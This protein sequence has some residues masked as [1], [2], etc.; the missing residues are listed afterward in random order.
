MNPSEQE[1]TEQKILEL[2]YSGPGPNDALVLEM[3]KNSFYNKRF[4]G[5]L[6]TI[7]LTTQSEQLATEV[8]E[9]LA[10]HTSDQQILKIK[11]SVK[12]GN[13]KVHEHYLQTDFD[14]SLMVDILYTDFR[15]SGNSYFEFLKVDDGTHPDRKTI[16]QTFLN[17]FFN[18]NGY[19]TIPMLMPDELAI[20]LKEVFKN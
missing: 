2:I 14:R 19:V 8:I 17:S 5:P 3:L 16:F 7:A 9:F 20:Y 15:R 1:T 13:H 18:R 4:V 11:E 12:R 6:M 10:P